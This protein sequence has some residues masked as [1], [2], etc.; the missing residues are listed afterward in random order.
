MSTIRLHLIASQVPAEELHGTL[1]VCRSGD[2]VTVA[3]LRRVSAAEAASI[4]ILADYTCEPDMSDAK[5]TRCVLA[6][7]VGIQT[8]ADITVELRDI[9]N[10]PTLELVAGT[11]GREACGAAAGAIKLEARGEKKDAAAETP[12]KAPPTGADADA[13]HGA[14]RRGLVQTLVPHDIIGRLMI[15]CARQAHLAEVYDA[16]CGF[17]GCELYVRPWPSLQGKPWAEVAFSFDEACPIGVLRPAEA[18]DAEVGQNAALDAA[19]A[20]AAAPN[21][22]LSALTTT[23]RAGVPSV[24]LPAA[25]PPELSLRSS[26]GLSAERVRAPPLPSRLSSP[27]LARSRL[28]SPDLLRSPLLSGAPQPAGR[29]L[30]RRG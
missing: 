17:D 27:H 5:A 23:L 20:A 15:Q 26:A 6:L 30:A 22:A 18:S 19:R 3:D 29:L 14:R 21:L 24:R 13:H 28:I 11:K 16:L 1:V 8:V 2:P 7:R 12:A 25:V 4:V 9:D 10:R